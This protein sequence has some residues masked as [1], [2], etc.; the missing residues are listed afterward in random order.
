[1]NDPSRSRR[2]R[3]SVALAALITAA[4]KD[5]AEIRR[6]REARRAIARR[7]DVSE[8]AVRYWAAA[9]SQPKY[10]LKLIIAPFGVA[11]EWWKEPAGDEPTQGLAID[12]ESE[13]APAAAQPQGAG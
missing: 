10:E 13:P 5:P 8:Q 2:T 1:M 3:A 11:L 4:S 9:V 6:A 12:R 7:C